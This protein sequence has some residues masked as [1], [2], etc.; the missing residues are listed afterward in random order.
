MSE[1]KAKYEVTAPRP[2]SEAE[3]PPANA[4]AADADDAA[5]ENAAGAEQPSG[6]ERRT[7]IAGRF[8]GFLPVIVDVETGGFNSATDALLEVAA[9]LVRL[10]P[11]G[12][13]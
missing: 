9:I 2:A 11:A 6:E 7:G 12:D 1:E 10:N 13:L 3:A 8:R 4:R 5:T